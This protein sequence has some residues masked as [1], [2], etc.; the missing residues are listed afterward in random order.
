MK[1][2]EKQ[3]E[4]EGREGIKKGCSEKRIEQE[5]RKKK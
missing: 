4:Q 2:T 5:R 1:Y 3:K